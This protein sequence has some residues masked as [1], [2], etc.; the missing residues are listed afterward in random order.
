[1]SDKPLEHEVDA[2][3]NSL[4][5]LWQQQQTESVGIESI[6]RKW[7]NIKLKQRVYF[8]VD[9]VG[10]LFMVAVCYFAFD[11]MGLFAKTWMAI[12]TF[13]AGATAVYFSYLRRF[14]L[15]WS[16]EGTGSYI[17]QLKKQLKS[18][19][20]IAKLNRDMS[21]WMILA[22]A[23][24]YVGMFYFDEVVLE[25]A[26]RKGLISLA[27]LAVFTPPFWLWANRRAKRFTR[28]LMLLE[29]ALDQDKI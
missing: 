28:E 29:Q 5:S 2:A 15:N 23:I 14:A 1:M 9:F 11:K 4:N 10:V 17:E 25:T 3:E 22:I 26:V 18:N 19:I 24:F 12:L 8:V 21:L 16:N 20:R 7:L 6:K 13:F 27:I